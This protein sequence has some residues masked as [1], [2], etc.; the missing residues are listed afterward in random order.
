[1]PS[2]QF[3]D[4]QQKKEGQAIATAIVRN[5]DEKDMLVPSRFG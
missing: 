5:R 3:K 1:M 4:V 2:S